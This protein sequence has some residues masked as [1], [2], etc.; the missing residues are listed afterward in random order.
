MQKP[1][2]L[3]TGKLTAWYETLLANLPNLVLGI[4]VFL[5]TI[6]LSQV[7]KKF[8]NKKLAD[9]IEKDSMRSLTANISSFAVVLLGL[10]LTLSTMNLDTAIESILAGAGVAGLAVGLALKG[11]L[12]NLFSGVVLSVQDIIN[13]GDWIETNGFSGT[14]EKIT[15]RNTFVREKD[16]NMVIIPNSTVLSN[17]FKNYGIT[18]SN[19]L[20]ISCGVHYDTDLRYVKKVLLRMIEDNFPPPSEDK[21]PQ[22]FFNNFGGSSIDFEMRF[23]FDPNVQ[24]SRMEAKSDAIILIQEYFAEAEINIPYPIRTLLHEKQEENPES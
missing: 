7:V 23:W 21:Q 13:V 20:I 2:E 24:A 19:K 6:W 5:L 3:I 22:I 10:V 8:I 18:P 4:G 17:P 9:K 15:L 1:L 16:N 14:V 11:A 12:S